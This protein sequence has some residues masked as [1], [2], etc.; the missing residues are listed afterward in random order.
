[1]SKA[2]GKIVRYKRK[3]LTDEQIAELK[4]LAE[5]PDEEI[6][7]SDIPELDDA[8]FANAVQGMMY[9][10]LHKQQLTLRIDM[11]IVEWFKSQAGEDG[12]GYQTDMNNALRAYMLAH[13]KIG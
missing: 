12:R 11:D 10:R 9:R 7:L 3:P 2:E 8:F 5:K 13:R 6:D 4:A 1:M